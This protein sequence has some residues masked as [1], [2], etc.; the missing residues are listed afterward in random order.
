MMR[1]DTNPDKESCAQVFD[2][3][4][5]QIRYR[6]GYESRRFRLCNQ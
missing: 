1:V 4:E 5:Y 3:F 2:E 6:P